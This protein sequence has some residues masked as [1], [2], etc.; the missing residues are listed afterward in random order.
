MLHTCLQLQVYLQK[1][2]CEHIGPSYMAI[3]CIRRIIHIEMFD[4]A[5]AY[6]TTNILGR[7]VSVKDIQSIPVRVHCHLLAVVST[8]YTS[9]LACIIHKLNGAYWRSMPKLWSMHACKSIRHAYGL[10]SSLMDQSVRNAQLRRWE[11]SCVCVLLLSGSDI[12]RE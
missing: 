1:M 9:C 5:T 6:T 12:L 10:I 8:Y 2:F 4:E 11:K 7:F 3:P